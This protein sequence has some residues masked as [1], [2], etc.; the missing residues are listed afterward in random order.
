MSSQTA[1]HPLLGESSFSDTFNTPLTHCLITKTTYPIFV[2]PGGPDARGAMSGEAVKLP[3]G[4]DVE[5]KGRLPLDKRFGVRFQIE[6]LGVPVFY[7]YAGRD[8]LKNVPEA[9]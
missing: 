4:A 1:V 9:E 5:I 6:T 7:A 2:F 3:A 8:D